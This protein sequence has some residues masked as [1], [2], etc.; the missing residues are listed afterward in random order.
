MP[1]PFSFSWRRKG[2]QCPRLL[3]A[4]HQSDEQEVHVPR[5]GEPRSPLDTASSMS[6]KG[7]VVA[8]YRETCCW[9]SWSPTLG[10]VGRIAWCYERQSTGTPNCMLCQP[11][12]ILVRPR[13]DRCGC[14]RRLAWPLAT[15][16]RTNHFWHLLAW[17]CRGRARCSPNWDPSAPPSKQ[18]RQLIFTRAVEYW[19]FC[20]RRLVCKHVGMC[21][22][23]FT[24]TWP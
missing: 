19:S 23:W 11:S 7:L 20:S 9:I 3:H 12:K 8:K 4:W 6:L 18:K 5:R 17:P 14:S 2:N 10:P 21:T 24:A 15:V 1:R 16:T 22:F 13:L